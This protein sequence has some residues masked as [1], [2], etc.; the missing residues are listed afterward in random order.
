M[1]ERIGNWTLKEF[2]YRCLQRLLRREE[3]IELLE[4]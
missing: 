4:S 1:G 3:I 2:F